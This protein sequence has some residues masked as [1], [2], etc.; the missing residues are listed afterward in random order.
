[1][2]LATVVD[3]Y[4]HPQNPVIGARS[5]GAAPEQVETLGLAVIAGLQDN[6]VLAC[7][8][9]F[10]GHGDTEADSHK[11]LPTVSHGLGRLHEI[12]L[13]PFA[14]CFQNGLAAVMTAHVRYPALDPEHPA[15]LS[16]AILTD[17]LRS[18][19][20]STG[21]VLTPALESN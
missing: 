8:K 1:M 18:P 20:Q 3:V 7:G 12:E 10:P 17:L 13:R 19:L 16:P 5:F 15:T 6:G 4:S 21:L 2:T 14:H 9:H 11:E